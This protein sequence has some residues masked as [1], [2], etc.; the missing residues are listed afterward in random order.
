MTE[1]DV[2][3]IQKLEFKRLVLLYGNPIKLEN[4]KNKSWKIGPK[5]IIKLSGDTNLFNF[6]DFDFFD[7][8]RFGNWNLQ[9]SFGRFYCMG[10]LGLFKYENKIW[11]HRY[12]L[13][14][15]FVQDS[16]LVTDHIDHIGT[17][18]YLSN[19]RVATRSQNLANMYKL[20]IVKG[21]DR[22]FVF[23]GVSKYAKNRWRVKFSFGGVLIFN[24]IFKNE[25]EAACKYDELALKYHGE[26]AKLNFPITN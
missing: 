20:N 6:S 23:K 9:R 3:L 5:L 14:D 10:R 19:L 24:G 11:F 26:F 21:I 7:L 4:C 22:T 13:Q 16:N 18:N 1:T 17:F 25:I 8:V 2:F 15:I 12:I